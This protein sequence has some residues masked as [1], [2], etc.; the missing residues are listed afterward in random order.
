MEGQPG[1]SKLGVPDWGEQDG[2]EGQRAGPEPKK[3]VT[4]LCEEDFSLSM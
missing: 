1:K 2:L 4:S 3:T